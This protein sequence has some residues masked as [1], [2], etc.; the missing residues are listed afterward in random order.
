[1]RALMP[2]QNLAADLRRIKLGV[3]TLVK[4]GVDTVSVT[5]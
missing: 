2:P 4:P 5:R 1:M 3:D